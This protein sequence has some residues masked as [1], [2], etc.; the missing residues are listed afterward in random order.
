MND[1][2]EKETVLEMTRTLAARPERV[3]KAWTDPR[4]MEQWF[5]PHGMTSAV[6]EM[7]VQPGGTFHAVISGENDHAVRGVYRVIDPPHRL[8][9]SWVWQQGDLKDRETE[10]ELTFV[11]EGD[12][13]LMTLIHRD[14]PSAD[15]VV[16][17][18]GG[19]GSA[20]EKLT[21]QMANCTQNQE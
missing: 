1:V 13:T 8:V 18:N 4:I 3:F 5:G 17:H 14:L 16:S 12:G 10:V 7:D 11:P 9:F 15:S 21:D 2:M 6:K 20:I 19:W